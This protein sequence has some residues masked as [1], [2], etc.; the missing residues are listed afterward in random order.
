MQI[1]EQ[2][3]QVQLIRSPYDPTKKRCVQK[4]VHTFQ[5]RYSYAPDNLNIYL[6]DEQ[7]ADLSDDEKKTLSDWMKK[8]AD[9]RKTDDR[10]YSI[11]LADSNIIKSADAISAVGVDA[12]K[13]STIWAAIEKLSKVLKKAG[14]P[15]GKSK[16]KEVEKPLP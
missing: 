8:K 14:H 15:K 10:L 11:R 2:G 1:R 6:S 13:A 7:L 3:R 12:E 5:Q 4:V 16:G 9:K